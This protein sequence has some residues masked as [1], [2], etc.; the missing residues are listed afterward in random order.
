VTP[1]EILALYLLGHAERHV[2]VTVLV[3]IMSRDLLI[4]HGRQLFS[5]HH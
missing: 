1:L 2:W 3:P 4:G 5:G